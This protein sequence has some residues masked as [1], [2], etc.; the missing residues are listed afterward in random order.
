MDSSKEAQYFKENPDFYKLISICS[1]NQLMRKTLFYLEN[2]LLA[3]V[4]T[5]PC[6]RMSHNFLYELFKS[7]PYVLKE[8]HS[9]QS[10]NSKEAIRTR[11]ERDP[12]FNN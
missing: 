6:D 4:I 3:H 9:W 8:D 11:R 7:V 12:N 10:E 2:E 5:V 1:P